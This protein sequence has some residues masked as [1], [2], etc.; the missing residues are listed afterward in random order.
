MTLP[1]VWFWVVAFLW[2]G[3]FVLEGFDFGVG[4][5]HKVV[6]RTDTEQRVAINTIGPFWDG[7]EVWLIVG[8]A[9]IFAAFPGWYATWFSA[10]Y[11][12]VV[13]LLVALM[14]RGVSFEFRGRMD[15]ARWRH[16]WSWCLTV[17]SALCPLLLGV[18]L[19]NLLAGL[20]VDADEEFTGSVADIV[21]GY[22]L[23]VGVTMLALCVLHGATFLVLRTDG[24]VRARAHRIA[25]VALWPTAALLVAFA[26]WTPSLSDAP[27]LRSIG[28]P[29]AA[30][31][32]VL[33]AAALL[34]A[35]RDGWSFAATAV[36]MALTVVSVF[37]NLY[38][39]VLVSSTDAANN[40]TVAGTASGQYALQVMTVVAAF[41]VP[42][43]L[44]YQG[45]SYVVFRRRVTGP[46][47]PTSTGP[48]P[49]PSAPLDEGALT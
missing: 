40:L 49:G 35:H 12:A 14:A 19:G 3:F 46:P 42:V 30:L 37:T 6:G 15:S 2:T 7:N 33:A 23:L 25:S 34:R 44:L 16:T 20:P 31:V 11:L 5:L 39:N 38:P 36:G 45:W 26:V 13:L 21:T 17:G 28:P 32:A 9:A 10:L 8:G 4:M 22:G 24:L 41:L 47:T 1:I 18:A 43:V 48:A 29:V 27:A